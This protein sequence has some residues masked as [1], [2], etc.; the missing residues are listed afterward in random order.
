MDTTERSWKIWAPYCDAAAKE[1]WTVSDCDGSEN[2]TPYQL[3][4]L[5][6]AAVFV[7]DSAAWLHVVT[8]ARN[9]DA[10]AIKALEFIRDFSPKE[11]DYISKHVGTAFP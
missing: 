4:A 9:G 11:Y 5:D 7:D 10:L 2:G 6:E 3:Q 1:G 8:N